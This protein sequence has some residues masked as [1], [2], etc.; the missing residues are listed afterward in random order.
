MPYASAV[1]SL[2]YAMVYTR[3]DLSQAISMVSRYMHDPDRSHW[4]AVEWILR[5]IKGTI[6]I[7]LEFK[8][9]V[10]SKQECIKYIDSDYA[11]DLN[12]R[13]SITG[14]TLSQA[15]VSWRSTLQ[16]TV[17]LPTMEAKYMAMTGYK[18]GHLASRAAW[19]LRD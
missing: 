15:E 7:G 1:S 11:G 10:A 9:D 12:K 6:D 8:K 5:Y 19:R 14:F 4:E 13:Q 18:G 16:S 3:P 17:A 2:I